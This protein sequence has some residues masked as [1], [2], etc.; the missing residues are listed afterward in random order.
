MKQSWLGGVLG[1]LLLFVSCAKKETT[2][3][4]EAPTLRMAADQAGTL[5]YDSTHRQLVILAS[6]MPGPLYFICSFNAQ[7]DS[8]FQRLTLPQNVTFSGA[9]KASCTTDVM[10]FGTGVADIGLT[11]LRVR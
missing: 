9:L 6:P 2:C 7:A 5:Y 10:T 3:G 11:A 8:V 1:L 4:C